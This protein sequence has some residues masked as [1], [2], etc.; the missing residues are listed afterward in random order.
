MIWNIIIIKYSYPS[1]IIVMDLLHVV[2][3][4]GNNGDLGL[5]EFWLGHW[6]QR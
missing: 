3:L 1:I 6:V 4:G 2:C 5:N